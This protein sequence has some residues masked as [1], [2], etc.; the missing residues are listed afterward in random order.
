[1]SPWNNRKE[2]FSWWHANEGGATGEGGSSE[3]TPTTSLSE[4][5]KKLRNIATIIFYLNVSL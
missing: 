3:E 2:L 5:H 1:M 4:H